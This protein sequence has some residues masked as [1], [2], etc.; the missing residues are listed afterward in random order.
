MWVSFHCQNCIRDPV[1]P[2]YV[3]PFKYIMEKWG[4][5]SAPKSLP[6]PLP[7]H[8]SCSVYEL[9]RAAE[10]APGQVDI[11]RQVLVKN[12][13]PL[14]IVYCV[15]ETCLGPCRFTLGLLVWY[16]CMCVHRACLLF[17]LWVCT[18]VSVSMPA[19]MSDHVLSVCKYTF[20]VVFM[21][22]RQTTPESRACLLSFFTS[23]LKTLLLCAHL[24]FLCPAL[25]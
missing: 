19:S 11:V 5:I 12:C 23:C 15:L 2:K 1:S 10:T 14:M 20:T 6:L 17:S 25:C 24:F 4:M 9:Q 18:C 16:I 13:I 7:P 21:A 8:W 3:S 22:V